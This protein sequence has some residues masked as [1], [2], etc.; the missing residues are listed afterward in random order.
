MGLKVA[1]SGA[2]GRMGRRVGDTL[3]AMEGI[4]FVAG[5]VRPSQLTVTGCKAPLSDDTESTLA[6]CDVLLDFTNF[7][8]T[9]TLAALCAK[10]DRPLFVGTTAPTNADLAVLEKRTAD[11]PI[12]YAPNI[13]WG[14]A[15]LFGI[16]ETLS[17]RL[18]P[19]YDAKIIGVHHREK[20]E[21]PSGTSAE[22]ARRI[23]AG[24]DEDTPPEIVSLRA[25]G[26]YSNHEIIFAGHNDE[27]RIS[28]NVTR[29]DIDTDV[30]LTACKWL[31]TK[32]PGFYSLPEVLAE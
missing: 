13:S 31:T 20:K 23:Q 8:R 28:H 24:R 30:L 26:A 6:A 7:D 29:P 27:I 18:G 3:D 12:L 19:A 10:L 21:T 9:L 5:L 25:G 14:A 15:T 32:G 17:E 1:L 22:I 11:I 16:L 2:V 4:D